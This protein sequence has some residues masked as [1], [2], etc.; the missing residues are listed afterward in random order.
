MKLTSPA[1]LSPREQADQLFTRA[2]H[3][4]HL[5]PGRTR[6]V[7]SAALQAFPANLLFVC[8]F[9]HHLVRCTAQCCAAHVPE[10]YPSQHESHARAQHCQSTMSTQEE[11]RHGGVASHT[12]H[13]CNALKPKHSTSNFR[14]LES[15]RC[16]REWTSVLIAA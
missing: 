12:A 16:S 8:M 9:V 7:H 11:Q 1:K 5:G 4:R 6:P 10:L 15:G 13:T 2:D 3:A 14:K